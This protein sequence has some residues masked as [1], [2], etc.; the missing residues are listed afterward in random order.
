MAERGVKGASDVAAKAL[1]AAPESAP[2]MDTVAK[3]LASEGM[4]DRAVDMQKQAIATMPDRHVYRLNLARLFIRAGKHQEAAA[5]LS[6]LSKLD[7]K[8]G[9]QPEVDELRKQ[10]PK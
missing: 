1:K 2:V 7:A 8:L 6:A 9:L 3:A 5:E 4:L 10:L